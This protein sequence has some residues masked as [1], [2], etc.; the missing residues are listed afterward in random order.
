MQSAAALLA[1]RAAGLS[2]DW[3]ALLAE[4]TALQARAELRASAISAGVTGDVESLSWGERNRALS[5]LQVLQAA[6]PG[7]EW[8]PQHAMRWRQA[9]LDLLERE[10]GGPAG[11][12]LWQG[13][14]KDEATLG[15]LQRA[16]PLALKHWERLLRGAEGGLAPGKPG[17]L[18]DAQRQLAETMD[19]LG[20]AQPWL[21]AAGQSKVAQETQRAGNGFAGANR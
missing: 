10:P 9:L 8:A 4:R 11:R 5:A 14:G 7:D 3:P 15:R 19:G 21:A 20:A 13:W 16:A 12:W 1:E 17:G 18:A 6:F 2:R